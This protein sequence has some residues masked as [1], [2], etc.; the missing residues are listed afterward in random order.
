MNRAPV[1]VW[2]LVLMFT[3]GCPHAFGIEGTI[4]R[5]VLKDLIENASRKGCPEEELQDVCGDQIER[6][7]NDCLTRMKRNS[8]P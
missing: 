4:D 6:C 8:Y 1:A 3:P 2:L 7:V 5:A